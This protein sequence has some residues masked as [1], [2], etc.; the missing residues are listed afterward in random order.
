MRKVL[1]LEHVT[2]D[3]YVAGPNGEMDWIHLPEEIWQ[4]GDDLTATS[5][6]AIYGRVTYGMMAGYWPTAA[7]GPTPTVTPS[8]TRSGSTTPSATCTRTRWRPRPGAIRLAPS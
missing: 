4:F 1:L 6:A 2:L 5:D 7:D 3:G 8:T